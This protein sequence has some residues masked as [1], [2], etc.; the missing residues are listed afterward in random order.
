ME[1]CVTVRGQ[2][3]DRCFDSHGFWLFLWFWGCLEWGHLLPRLDSLALEVSNIGV[4]LT[5]CQSLAWGDVAVKIKVSIITDMK[6]NTFVKIVAGMALAAGMFS[7][8]QAADAKVDPSGTYVWTMAGRNGGPERTNTLVLKLEGDKLTGSVAAPGRGGA[9][10]TSTEIKDGK[11]TGSDISFSVTREFNGN[12]FT[13]KYS[14]K[15]ADGAIKGKT[16]TDRN[17]EVQS[18]DWEAKKQ[19]AKK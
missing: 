10:P 13:T 18:R 3:P 1:V 15:L 4:S 2:E 19:E 7:P 8:V 6:L 12:S 14:G 11:I 5:H 16:E 17:G 9:E